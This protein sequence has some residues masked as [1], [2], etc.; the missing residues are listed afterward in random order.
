VIV[1]STFEFGR[2]QSQQAIGPERIANAEDI[3]RSIA[4]QPD[5][6]VEVD[7]LGICDA[8]AAARIE[9]LTVGAAN[10]I[11]ANIFDEQKGAFGDLSYRRFLVTA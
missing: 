8:M 5:A 9:Q 10:R 3:G 7:L 4:V 1:R 6:D 2:R 11:I